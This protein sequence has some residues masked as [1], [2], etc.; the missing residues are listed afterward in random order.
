MSYTYFKRVISNV[1]EKYISK[2]E[3]H[4]ERYS[5]SAFQISIVRE[6]RQKKGSSYTIVFYK[7]K[8]ERNFP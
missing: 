4:Y 2:E 1:R 8:Q 3:F 7:L 5:W 6:K